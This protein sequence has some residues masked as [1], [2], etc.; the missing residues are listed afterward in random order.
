M[1][2]H[3]RSIKNRRHCQRQVLFGLL[4]QPASFGTVQERIRLGAIPS[5]GF[6]LEI[7]LGVLLMYYWI[8]L[9]LVFPLLLRTNLRF[10]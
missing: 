1:V 9:Q 3:V 6:A 4:N 8:Q 7:G 2:G 5:P 10:L